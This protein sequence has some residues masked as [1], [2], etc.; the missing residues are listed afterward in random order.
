MFVYFDVPER[1]I[2]AI[3]RQVSYTRTEEG[4]EFDDSNLPALD[5]TA[6]EQDAAF[7]DAV[8][9][10]GLRGGPRLQVLV[11]TAVDEDFPHQGEIDFLGNTVDE[12][13]GTIEVRGILPNARG[14]LVPGLFVRVRIPVGVV[15]DAIL[16][17][18]RA[19]GTDLGG[20]YVYVVGADGVV[21]QRYVTLGVTEPDG[22]VPV[23]E[24]LE[25]SDTYIA[26][27]VLRARPGMPVTPTQAG[28][29]D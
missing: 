28:S 3:L 21:E 17:D 12:S 27:G 24:G 9:Q 14:L 1:A 5:T 25:L 26:E 6:V 22:M 16:I 18:E 13:T 8:S 2:L 29:A 7:A 19:L 15:E 23:T 4:V 20:Q 11:S 10:T